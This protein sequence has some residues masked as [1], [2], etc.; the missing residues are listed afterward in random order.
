[1]ATNWWDGM[2][3]E[4]ERSMRELA[5]I[6]VCTPEE[7]TVP[8][9]AGGP[10][11]LLGPLVNGLHGAETMGPPGRIL[12]GFYGHGPASLWPSRSIILRPVGEPWPLATNLDGAAAP[13]M[14]ETIPFLLPADSKSP[15]G[16]HG[17]CPPDMAQIEWRNEGG[18]RNAL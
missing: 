18:D 4:T 1:M 16:H 5:A 6:W 2:G 12:A 9:V 13:R 3:P 10:I 11:G 14:A 15:F 7:G 17:Q 8:P